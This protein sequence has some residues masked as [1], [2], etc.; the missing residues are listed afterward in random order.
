MRTLSCKIYEEAKLSTPYVDYSKWKKI[1]ALYIV[2]YTN[3]QILGTI[4][5]GNVNSL[6]Y[7]TI[8]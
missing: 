6:T 2:D 1:F 4:G 5:E 3:V 7:V 8:M